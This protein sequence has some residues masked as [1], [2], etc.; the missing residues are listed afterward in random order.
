MQTIFFCSGHIAVFSIAVC[1]IRHKQTIHSILSN[2]PCSLY[3]QTDRNSRMLFKLT[4]RGR[5]VRKLHLPGRKQA[6]YKSR[7][8]STLSRQPIYRRYA[9][10]HRQDS[11]TLFRPTVLPALAE[12]AI[13]PAFYYRNRISVI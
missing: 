9:K 10:Q 5:L 12:T 1:T 13:Q 7:F 11:N 3:R 6:C 4:Q 8:R 2:R